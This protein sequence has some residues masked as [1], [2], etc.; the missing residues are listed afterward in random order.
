MTKLDCVLLLEPDI[1]ARQ[2][3]ADFL[4]ECGFR[5]LEAASAPEALALLE[6]EAEALAVDAVLADAG[7]NEAEVF[8]LAQWIRRTCPD[9]AV[10]LAGG[11][12]TA[13]EQAGKL[14]DEGPALVK[15]YDHRAVLRHI[16]RLLA[17]R[18]K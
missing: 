16:K 9:V 11:V 4:R 17:R 8:A 6:A 5:V 18:G 15:P 13:A 3:L 7:G 2:P 10:I 12:E 1:I 14:C